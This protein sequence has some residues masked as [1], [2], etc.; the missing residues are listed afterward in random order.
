LRGRVREGGRRRVGD[1]LQHARKILQHI[2][3]PETEHAVTLRRKPTVT[4][5]IARSVSMLTAIDLD[6][7][8][9]FMTSK[10]DD[11]SADGRLTAK[12]KPI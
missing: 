4:F 8:M 11:V 12:A 9:L 6:D 2:R 1:C 10:V 5:S 3:I 7:Q